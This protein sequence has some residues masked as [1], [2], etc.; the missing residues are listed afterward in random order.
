MQVTKFRVQAIRE[1]GLVVE[2]GRELA[3]ASGAAAGTASLQLAFAWP[4]GEPQ[5]LKFRLAATD[6]T[7]VGEWSAETGVVTVG[8]L[9]TVWDWTSS[10]GCLSQA[11]RGGPYSSCGCGG[12]PCQAH[13]FDAVTS[14]LPHTLC[15]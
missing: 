3:L 15:E 6:S 11:G 5:H 14:S 7:F 2:A 10:S 1:D 4:S 13:L 8:E 9:A 12:S